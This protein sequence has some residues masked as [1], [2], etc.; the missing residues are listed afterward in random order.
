MA[1][2]VPLN[3]AM[4]RTVAAVYGSDHPCTL[5]V[6]QVSTGS[7]WAAR[8][9]RAADHDLARVC[10]VRAVPGL[11][12]WVVQGRRSSGA[13]GRTMSDELTAVTGAAAA[14]VPVTGYWWGP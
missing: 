12:L 3:L 13:S 7:S 1:S 5:D 10:R 6:V 9:D 11:P 8:D 2:A 14:G 4:P